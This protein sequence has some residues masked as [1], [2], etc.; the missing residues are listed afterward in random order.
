MSA[1][2]PTSPNGPAFDRQAHRRRRLTEAAWLLPA[3]GAALFL[4]PLL[5]PGA[6][7]TAEGVEPVRTSRAILYIFGVWAGLI[8]TALLFGFA[9]RRLPDTA[10]TDT[11]GQG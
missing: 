10:G 4:I 11:S 8:C 7:E 6:L 2:E 9:V 3:A 1:G 5:W